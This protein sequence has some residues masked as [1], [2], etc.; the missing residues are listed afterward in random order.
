VSVQLPEEAKLGVRHI[1]AKRMELLSA[2][3]PGRKIGAEKALLKI[4]FFLPLFFCQSG[5][6]NGARAKS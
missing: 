4:S 5:L 6:A 2:R 3:E 1:F